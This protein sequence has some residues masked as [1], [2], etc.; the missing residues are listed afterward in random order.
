MLPRPSPLVLPLL[1]AMGTAANAAPAPS[2]PVELD[3][4]QVQGHRQAYATPATRSATKTDAALQDVPQAVSIVTA[5]V[6]RDLGITNLADALRI[7][8]GV[9]VAQGEGNRDAPILRG[10]ATTADLFI[11]GMRD[12]VQ[13]VRDIYNVERVE[14]LK[15]PNAMIFGHGGAG[16][17]INRV[18][19]VAD[20]D[21][22]REVSLQAGSFGRRRVTFDAGEST[23]DTTAFRVTGLLEDSESFR[24]GFALRRDG[25][26]PT[27][28]W[29]ASEA[30]RLTFGYER[31]HDR[32]VADRGVPSMRLVGIDRPVEV[33]PHTFFGSA[34]Q[35]PVEARVDAL[36]MLVEHR[37]SSGASLRNQTRWADYGKF[38][39]NVY[40][41]GTARGADGALQAVLGAYNNRTDRR[42]LFN[43]TDVTIRLGNGA[44]THTLLGGF[45]FGRQDTSNLRMTGTFPANL[46][47]GRVQTAAACVPV[48]NP[49]YDR[50]VTFAPS[51]TDARNRSEA[52]V[53]AVYLQ[54]QVELSPQWQ[55]IIGARFDRFDVDF[56]NERNGERI[57]SRDSLWSP[58]VGLVWK[59]I[60]PLSVYTSY[61]VTY[62]P[63]AGEQLSSLSARTRSFDPEKF[64]NVEVGAKWEMRPGLL[65]TAAA[66]R[67]DRSNVVAPDPVD[68]T[69]SILVDGQ[70][71]EGI[72][73]EMAGRVTERWDVLAGYAYQE[74]V[75][76]KR[77]SALEPAGTRLAQL[78]RHSAS[79]WNRYALTPRWSIG[80]GLT[81]RG[82]SFAALPSAGP[83]P[84]RTVLAPYT[85]IDAGLYYRTSERLRVQLNVEN[86]LDR[87]YFASAHTNDNIS[88]G[89][90]RAVY[91]GM[92]LDF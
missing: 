48:S 39:Q 34:A 44:V 1:A 84:N 50:P 35:S 65:F 40:P 26:N 9:G 4:V 73:L 16:G 63:R 8:P 71:N 12:D 13:Y 7:L 43:Q 15:G 62:L 51:A 24:D 60:A 23:G 68:A 66:Y 78:P 28:R 76:T 92:T 19:K 72:E 56:L 79:L 22:H 5:E 45:E 49:R 89:S 42:N 20:R 81:Y 31:F 32:R 47:A 46:C 18:T 70:R 75:L 74:G 21:R 69:R 55:A 37:L 59:P 52:R 53:A 61:S 27:F 54:D 29:D 87:K 10:I 82:Q 58:R 2:T 57:A 14:V 17:I 3:R 30:T 83:L 67:L 33:D 77:L 85:R 25:I 86:L 88:P 38:Y 36:T 80:A 64:R 90:P 6:I 41:S 91:V 11:D